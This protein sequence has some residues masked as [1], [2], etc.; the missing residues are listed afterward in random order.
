MRLGAGVWCA[1]QLADQ[2]CCR[3]EDWIRAGELHPGGLHGAFSRE[4][5][6]IEA[7][8]QNQFRSTN[9]EIPSSKSWR[10][11]GQRPV[12]GNGNGYEVLRIED[13]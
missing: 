7:A 9:F 11:Y 13:L 3:V 12:N 1:A 6:A 5:R 4:M 2:S 10:G 8:N